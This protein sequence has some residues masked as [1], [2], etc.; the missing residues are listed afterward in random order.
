MFHAALICPDMRCCWPMA[1]VNPRCALET[2]R[3]DIL[4][5]REATRSD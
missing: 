3:K 2:N 1:E 4:S 5:S